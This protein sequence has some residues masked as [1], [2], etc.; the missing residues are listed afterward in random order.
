MTE[1]LRRQI[2]FSIGA[3]IFCP[4]ALART[5]LSEV[6]R[7]GPKP[8]L[9]KGDKSKGIPDKV[10]FGHGL[11]VPMDKMA[12]KTLW[13]GDDR[14]ISYGHGFGNIKVKAFDRAE[15]AAEGTMKLFLLTLAFKP[16]RL[17]R[18]DGGGWQLKSGNTADLVRGN[19][20]LPGRPI[21][22]TWDEVTSAMV[23][24]GI[25]SN[26]ASLGDSDV[27]SASATEEEGF[28]ATTGWLLWKK[29]VTIDTVRRDATLV[30]AWAL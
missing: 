2:L 3:G 30:P 12:F 9:V 16:E 21:M 11:L 19:I 23:A 1:M 8:A 25:S 10:D 13:E 6:L 17:V 4:P 22:P 5:T 15:L 26:Y 20:R 14:W 29:D 24:D 18:V 7:V 28:H 27:S